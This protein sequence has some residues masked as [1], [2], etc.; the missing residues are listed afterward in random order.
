[1]Q[2][3]LAEEKDLPE[4]MEIIRQAQRRIGELGIDQWQDGY[5]DESVIRGDLDRKEGY[6][7]RS[8][9]DEPLAYMAVS[10]AGEPNYDVIYEGDWGAD[11]AYAVLHRVAVNENYLRRGAGAALVREAQA[12]CQKQGVSCMR[13][14][15]HAGNLPMQRM[16]EK[17]GFERRGV[18]LLEDH[19]PRVAFDRIM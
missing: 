12:M 3:Q 19:S 10:F 8:E 6:L 18:I 15:T 4:I 7:L 9:A 2:L 17:N 11:V 1:M 16:L 5:P 14:D 13:V